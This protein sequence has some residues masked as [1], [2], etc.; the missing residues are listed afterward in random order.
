M[1]R[2]VNVRGLRTPEQRAGVCYVGRAWAGWPASSWG[3]PYKPRP[4][5]FTVAVCLERFR[6]LAETAQPEYL[7]DLWAACCGGAKPLG[8]WC[9]EATAGD[10]SPVVCHAQVLAEL[11]A[12]RFGAKGR[13]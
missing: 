2:V 11:L 13:V 12:D 8:C 1:I 10:G 3:N 7:V 6:E 9:V 4:P 5:A